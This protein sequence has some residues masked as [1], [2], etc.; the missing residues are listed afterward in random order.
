VGILFISLLIILTPAVYERSLK[1][2]AMRGELTL[3]SA[4]LLGQLTE[5]SYHQYKKLRGAD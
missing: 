2:L 1:G 5:K 3:V 4:V